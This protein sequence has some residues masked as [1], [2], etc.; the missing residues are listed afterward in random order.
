M[1]HKVKNAVESLKKTG[2]GMIYQ[3]NAITDGVYRLNL[4]EAR[5]VNLAISKIN[6]KDLPDKKIRITAKEF[7][8]IYMIKDYF[9]KN[10]LSAIGDSLTTRTIDTFSV[11][12]LTGKRT[13]VRN[14]WVSRIEYDIEDEGDSFLEITFS[15]EIAELIFQLK[16]NFTEIELRSISSFSSPHTFRV[17]SWLCKFK[18]LEKNWKNGCIVTDKITIEDFKLMLGIDGSYA[19]Y[20]FLKRNVLEKIITEINATTNTTVILNEFKTARKVTSISFTFVLESDALKSDSKTLKPERERLPS[21]PKAK[22]K[23]HLEGEWAR[24]CIALLTDYEKNLKTY[25]ESLVLPISDLEK[26]VNYYKII[27][28]SINFDKRIKELDSRRNKS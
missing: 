23:T 28:D 3:S 10:R 17:Y 16:G 1:V 26:L 15:P 27:G 6:K 8:E 25:D 7:L 22:S 4:D 14:L 9:I 18:K 21:R 20:K 24:S 11:D 12:S 13:R 5:L 19:E 2:E